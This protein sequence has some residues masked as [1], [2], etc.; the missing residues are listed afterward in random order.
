MVAAIF[1]IVFTRA[2]RGRCDHIHNHRRRGI[3]QRVPFHPGTL[4]RRIG[5]LVRR[6]RHH[7][8]RRTPYHRLLVHFVRQTPGK[9]F[10]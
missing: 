1:L 10:R 6:Q 3:G 7:R 9:G 8:R 4:S 2:D 5:C